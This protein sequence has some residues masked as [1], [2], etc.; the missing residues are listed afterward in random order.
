[1]ALNPATEEWRSGFVV[2]KTT[3]VLIAT[4]DT[5]GA[6][7]WGGFLRDPDGRIVVELVA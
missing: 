2:N 7:W 1:M 3:G 5:S 4:T 6:T